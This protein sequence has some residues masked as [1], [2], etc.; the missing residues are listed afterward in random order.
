MVGQ[1]LST[2]SCL[3]ALIL[4]HNPPTKIY[5]RNWASRW[6]PTS[7]AYARIDSWKKLSSTWVPHLMIRISVNGF[8]LQKLIKSQKS[9]CLIGLT[10]FKLVV[11]HTT[12]KCLTLNK[13]TTSMRSQISF[14]FRIKTTQMT[15]YRTQNLI[16]HLQTWKTTCP[17][18]H[19]LFSI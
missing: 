7:L 18:N 17:K 15:L 2:H 14:S 5:Q 8:N 4:S 16:I 6:G 19:K 9:F 10:D 1:V 11:W 12:C 13:F 3:T